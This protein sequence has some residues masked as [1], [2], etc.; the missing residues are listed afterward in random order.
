MTPPVKDPTG[1]IPIVGFLHTFQTTCNSNEIHEGATM[2]L[3]PYFMRKSAGAALAAHLF[4]KSKAPHYS[5]YK[6]YFQVVNLPMETFDTETWS[7]RRME[8]WIAWKRCPPCRYLNLP[9]IFVW[10]HIGAH[11]FMMMHIFSWEYYS[12]SCCSSIGTALGHT[13]AV[14]KL[15]RCRIL[16]MKPLQGR[17]NKGH[18]T[19]GKSCTRLQTTTESRIIFNRIAAEERWIT[20]PRQVALLKNH[21]IVEAEWN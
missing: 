16:H 2:G 11:T 8:G 20:W 7:P 6:S 19:H 18:R 4:L 10:R 13:E 14:A 5:V 3:F 9:M 15:P 1:P 21:R 17:S 12:K